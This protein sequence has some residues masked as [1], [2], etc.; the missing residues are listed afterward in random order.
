[1]TRTPTTTPTYTP[2]TTPTASATPTHTP[3][4]TPTATP[5]RPTA[6]PTNTSTPNFNFTPTATTIPTAAA[7][8]TR[9]SFI[10]TLDEN[11]PV[12][13]DNF[14]NDEGCNWLG[15]AGEVRDLAGDPVALESYR[16]HIWE[17]GLDVR[18]DVGDAPV[19]NVAGWEQ[20]LF[21]SPV[22]L[23]YNVQL[24]TING[25]PVSLVYQFQTRAN[26]DE[27]LVYII[28]VQNH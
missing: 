26:C 27:N 22:A 25:T 23:E 10:F 24:E 11:T 1:V 16:V 14:S 17:N 20:Q 12:Y 5:T 21:D 13:R 28:F 9:S 19:Y 4:N 8:N 6:T 7:T 18:V 15:V 2:T 3:T